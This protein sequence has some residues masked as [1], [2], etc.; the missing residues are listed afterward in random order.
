MKF[1][2]LSSLA[3]LCFNSVAQIPIGEARK[4]RSGKVVTV[5]GVV[6]ASFGDLS[7]IQD[8]SGG[9]AVY[10]ISL[11]TDDSI[12]VT[13]KLT[14]YNSMPEIIIDSIQQLG[15][16]RSRQPEEIVIEDIDDHEGELIRIN[17]AFVTPA[18]LLFYPQRAGA[19]IQGKDTAQ[20]WIDENT[21]IPG[22]TIPMNSTIIGIVGRFGSKLQILPRSH[23]DIQSTYS[24]PAV[25]NNHFRVLNWNVEFFGAPRYGPT[26]DSLQIANV[27]SILNSVQADVI[28]LQEVSNDDAFRLL[29]ANMNGYG[30]R[31]SSRYSY[32]FDPTGDFPP[33]KLCFVYRTS[34]V[35]VIREKILFRKIFDDHPS[36]MFSSGRLPYL[37]E[38]EVNSGRFSIINIHGKSGAEEASYARRLSDAI[39]LKDTLDSYKDFILL[40]DFNDDV[41]RSIV[42]G[43][44]SPYSNIVADYICVSKT[45]SDAGWHSTISYDD[46]IDHQVI[47]SSLA[48]YHASTT[49]VNPFN[50]VLLYGKTTSD[51]LPV[52]SEFDMTRL[53][54]STQDK[55]PA[56]IFPNPTKNDIWF[57][58]DC[59][60]T[61]MNSVGEKVLEKQNAHPPISLG[62][63]APGLYIV[64][65]GGQPFR[66][67][68]N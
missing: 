16:G 36:D 44:E 49:I 66:I 40:G 62:E 6:T 8:T 43:H 37:L 38:V 22:Y 39:A 28:A 25:P 68:K 48:D 63:C 53:V 12:S 47:S 64:I 26:N 23:L 30:G 3:L 2:F 35:K 1:F 29:L 42:A 9:I 57:P 5:L 19:I 20:Y 61:V 21:D 41:D 33:Q 4:M 54:M 15:S 65:V 58:V 51:H 18:G 50:L 46:M 32:S 45:L 31:C 67:L 10:G 59:D 60:V 17:N 24:R 55:S 52:V 7:F 34:T 27:A 14:K 11:S 13:G 56:V